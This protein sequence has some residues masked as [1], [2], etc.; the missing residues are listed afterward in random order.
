VQGLHAHVDTVADLE[1]Q[2]RQQPRVYPG[3]TGFRAAARGFIAKGRGG[4]LQFAP[5][6]VLLV[7]RLDAGELDTVV[8]GNDAGKLH[9]TGVIQTQ[10][11]PGP[12]LFGPR[13]RTAF[14]H[15]VGPQELGGAQQH[16][17]V[18]AGTEVTDCSTGGHG[19]QQGEKQ[20]AQFAGTGI[21][22]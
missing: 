1:I 12:D 7:D 4:A 10:F 5:Q 17:A 19:H 11:S 14:E 3:F 13:R 21:A 20:H 2:G 9:D 16:G 22:Q 15:Q 8:G 18:K 6:W